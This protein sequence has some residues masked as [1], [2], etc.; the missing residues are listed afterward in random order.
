MKTEFNLEKALSGEHKVFTVSGAE[1]TQLT[2]FETR[3]GTGYCLAGIVDGQMEIW[4][5][6]GRYRMTTPDSLLNLK[7]APK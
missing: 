3:S 7:S 1:V 5:K 6:S 2:Y 4:M